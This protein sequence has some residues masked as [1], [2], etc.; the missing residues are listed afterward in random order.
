[1]KHGFKSNACTPAPG[2]EGHKGPI[3][4]YFNP[5]V[6]EDGIQFDGRIFFQMGGSKPTN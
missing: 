1:M 4:S 2:L 3:G 6:G 5:Y